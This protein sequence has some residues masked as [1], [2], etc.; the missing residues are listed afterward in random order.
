[1]RLHVK[2]SFSERRS[3]PGSDRS[4][5]KYTTTF[6]IVMTAPIERVNSFSLSSRVSSNKTSAHCHDRRLNLRAAR[7]SQYSCDVFVCDFYQ[8]RCLTLIDYRRN[9]CPPHS[10]KQPHESANSIP[11]LY[12]FG[13][14]SR[15]VLIPRSIER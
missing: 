3:S 13:N 6:N 5:M 1:M 8:P 10:S 11:S 15:Q 12:D 14:A 4:T 9:Q 7:L 2:L